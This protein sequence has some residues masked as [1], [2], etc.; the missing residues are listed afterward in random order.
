L[1]AAG[2]ADCVDFCILQNNSYT[3]DFLKYEIKLRSTLNLPV[4]IRDDRVDGEF[5]I[6]DRW[7]IPLATV[8][9]HFVSG[10]GLPGAAERVKS[11]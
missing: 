6:F 2:T 4:K 5:Y 8:N 9:Q 11:G 1:D 10:M 7:L 3:E